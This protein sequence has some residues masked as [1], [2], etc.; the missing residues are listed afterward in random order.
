MQLF[1]YS[2]TEEDSPAVRGKCR[3]ATKGDGAVSARYRM[4]EQL[5]KP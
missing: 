3:N 2:G 5:A 1:P 4:G